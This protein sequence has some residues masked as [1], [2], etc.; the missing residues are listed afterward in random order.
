M[1]LYPNA[2]I[3]IGLSVTEKRSDGFHNIETVF[4]PISLCDILTIEPDIATTATDE[5]LA[6]TCEGET[7]IGDKPYDNLCCKAYRLLDADY[8]LPPT[9]IRLYKTIPAG[10]GL[11][12]GS[13][14]ASYTLMALNSLYQLNISTDRLALYASCLGSDCAFFLQHNPAFGTGKGDILEPVSLS[15]AD[16]HILL[17]KPPVSVSTAAAYSAVIPRKAE[18]HLPE[19]IQFPVSNW[20]N[21]VVNDFEASVFRKFP[22]IGKIKERLYEEGA[23]YA[24]MS[25]SGA[26][27]FGIF[28]KNPGELSKLFSDCFCWYE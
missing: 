7:V 23:V 14:D 4:Y 15:L 8:D 6:F 16:Y 13:S 26:C 5:K 3:N 19:L 17:V 11:G 22:E 18:Y 12:G 2:K 9:S 24:S 28:N 21:T 10:A 20:R 27:V 1:I 25:G